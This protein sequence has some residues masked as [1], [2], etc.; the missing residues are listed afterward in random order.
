M[1]SFLFSLVSPLHW[2]C[3]WEPFVWVNVTG[4]VDRTDAVGSRRDGIQ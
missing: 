3:G 1:V 2:D 4:E